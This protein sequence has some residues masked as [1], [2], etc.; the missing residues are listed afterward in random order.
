MA[1]ARGII[2]TCDRSMLEFGGYVELN[3][4]WAYSLLRRMNFV[5]RK[6]TTAKS[7]YAIADFNR[8]KTEFLEDV[9]ATVEME[10][11]PLEL[12][13]NWDQTGIRIV[14]SNTWTMDQQGVKRVEIGGSGDKRQI[15]AVFCGSIV[16]DFLPI[17]L[18]YQGKT[19]RCHPRFE[20][21]PEWD[22]THSPKHWSNETTM[23]QYIE[24][25]I[26]PYINKVRESTGSNTPAM[27]IMDN[28]KG[29]VTA[30]VNSL[31]EAN[32]I[33]VCLLPPN[34]T[35]RLQPLD[36][37]VNKP[38]KDFLKRK[39]EDWYSNEIMKQLKGREIESAELQPINLGMPVLKELGARWIVEMAAYFGENPQIIVNGFVK[40]GITEALDGTID[41]G[42][43]EEENV[44]GELNDSEGDD[45]SVDDDSGV[46][47]LTGEDD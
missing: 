6:V 5:Q 30:A 3:R 9:V 20:F 46:M 14:P 2:L 21:P 34:T 10:E 47:D 32:S 28:F 44:R 1:A 31:L 43:E 11:I 7:K 12:I 19:A 25:I 38:A 29:Q 35:D 42:S 4:H 37:S 33:H 41:C 16:G 36:I 26:I 8:L 40:A 23:I 45:S 39:F 17:Q 22:I 13:L 24:K 18:I 15:T 27:I